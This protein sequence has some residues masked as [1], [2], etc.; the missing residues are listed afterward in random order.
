MIGLY[1]GQARVMLNEGSDPWDVDGAASKFGM[2]V[3]PFT[4]SDIVGLELGMPLGKER[5]K[6]KAAG[7]FDGSKNL[8]IALVEAGRKG[9]RFGS[10][11]YDYD[12]R[13]PKPSPVVADM[14]AKIRTNLGVANPRKHSEEEVVQRLLFPLVNEGFKILEEGMARR[15]ADIDVCY[16]SFASFR[17]ERQG[18][19]ETRQSDATLTHAQKVHGYSFPRRKGGPMFWA[20]NEAGL[21]KVKNMLESIGVKPAKLL[22]AC[23]EEGLTLEKYWKK[24][25][26]EVLKRA[27]PPKR[28]GAARSRM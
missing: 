5:E 27:G 14:L 2:R 17:A 25:G 28:R 20:D 1:G 18:E 21:E 11:Y 24:H 19:C 4:M 16:V 12:G 8:Q 10:G 7:K 3:G 26:A 23:I 15:P 13:R 9:Q 22:L 6:A